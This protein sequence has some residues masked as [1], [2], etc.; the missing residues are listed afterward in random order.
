MSSVRWCA[1]ALDAKLPCSL[2]TAQ[3]A[4]TAQRRSPL[5]PP[6][7]VKLDFSAIAG[8]EPSYDVLFSVKFTNG[9]DAQDID[10][11][12]QMIAELPKAFV[13]AVKQ[14]TGREVVTEQ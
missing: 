1:A 14:K 5:P 4:N 3:Y 10:I 9:H 13:A 12:Q 2:F 6:A 7:P 11:L 8:K